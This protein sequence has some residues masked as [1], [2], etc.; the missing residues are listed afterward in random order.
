MFHD[1][2]V[3]TG[4]RRDGTESFQ[5]VQRAFISEGNLYRLI[6]KSKKEEAEK[7]LAK[8]KKMDRKY[9]QQAE[10]QYAAIM[11][12]LSDKEKGK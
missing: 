10:N 1:A 7:F 12:M 11:K 9:Y 6:V 4:R 3:Q 2:R 5:I 8:S